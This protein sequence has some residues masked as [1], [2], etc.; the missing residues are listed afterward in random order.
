MAAEIEHLHPVFKARIERAC[1]E[2]GAAVLSG[3]RTRAEQQRLFDESQHGGAP[4]NPPGSSWHE[5]G[6]GLDG[7]AGACAVDFVS[8]GPN[9]KALLAVRERAAELGLC[10]PVKKEIWHAQP[11]EITLSS[12]FA[13]ARA[14]I[15]SPESPF[16]PEELELPMEFTYIFDDKDFL[17]LGAERIHTRCAVGD[18]LEGLKKARQIE[19]LGKQSERFHEFLSGI[20]KSAQFTIG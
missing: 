19:A 12:R 1:K 6:E 11:V 16:N 14:L 8:V 13:G 3:A 5:F 10:F 9:R 4:A 17:W 15:P 7:G 2:T 18:V 20:A